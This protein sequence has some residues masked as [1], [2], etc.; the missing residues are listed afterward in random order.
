MRVL[1]VHTIRNIEL[2]TGLY[3]YG[4]DFDDLGKYLYNLQKFINIT[5]ILKVLVQIILNHK[6]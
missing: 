6:L 5:Y 3:Y 1:F 4:H 2:G